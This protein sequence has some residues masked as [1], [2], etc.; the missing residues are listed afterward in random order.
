[1]GREEFRDAHLDL[2]SSPCLQT[3]IY[4]YFQVI[5]DSL[6]HHRRC[7]ACLGDSMCED[8]QE[9]LLKYRPQPVYP[10]GDKSGVQYIGKWEEGTFNLDI[11]CLFLSEFCYLEFY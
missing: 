9:H 7:P 8:V 1:M 3:F 11:F 6:T 4:A 5:P 2:N 10:E